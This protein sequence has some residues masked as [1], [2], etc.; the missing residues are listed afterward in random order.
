MKKKSPSHQVT[1]SPVQIKAKII[2][3]KEVAPA[4]FKLSIAA[5]QIARRAKPGQFLEI[6]V[7][8]TYQ[9]LLRK[10]LGINS[11]KFNKGQI[12]ILY[13]VVG[14]G[15]Q[16]LSKRK[17]GENLDILG[18]LGKGFD[19]KSRL[20]KHKTKILIGGGIGVAPLL[21][22]AEKIQSHQATKPQR[23]QL[24]VIIGANNKNQLLC[25]KEFKG[26]GCDVKIATDDG[27]KGLKGTATELLR[28]LLS[29]TEPRQSVIYVCGPKPMLKA[30]SA[31]GQKYCSSCYGLL[32]EYMACGTG[33]CFGC[34]V[35]TEA[36]FKRVCKDGPV[37][38][39][40]SI[41]W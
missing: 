31:I 21:F 22:L 14:K 5:P 10:P 18:P 27:S 17:K 39:L 32:E 38:E 15:T 3:N 19:Y 4:V 35:L 2:D 24:L 36:G 30:V 13:K 28:H 1:K 11:I 6:K 25:E 12:D 7:N 9:P 34:V 40:G 33:A 29:N 37:F 41:E 20:V 16:A 26:L 23:H 8:D